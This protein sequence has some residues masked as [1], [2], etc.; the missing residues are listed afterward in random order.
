[1]KWNFHTK[2]LN[3]NKLS[4]NKSKTN[5]MIWSGE[6]NNDNLED[7]KRGKTK[8]NRVLSKLSTKY[9][10]FYLMI[11]TDHRKNIF[12][13]GVKLYNELYQWKLR[14]KDRW[15]HWKWCAKNVWFESMI[16]CEL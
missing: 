16:L 2:W 8:I 10:G 5:C 4:L 13:Y 12:Y 11:T 15:I 9:S 1:M 3:E 6:N 14:K 7:V